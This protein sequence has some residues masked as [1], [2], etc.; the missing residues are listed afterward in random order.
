MERLLLPCLGGIVGA[1]VGVDV[2]EKV[3]DEG[4]G[5]GVEEGEGVGVEEGEVGAEE[6]EVLLVTEQSGPIHGLKQ[7]H[8]LSLLHTPPFTHAGEHNP[9]THD[10]PD[11][12]YTQ[13]DFFVF[14]FFVFVCLCCLY[15][16]LY[17]YLFL[18]IPISSS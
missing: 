6:G 1:G 10:F 16:F 13:L 2:V 15:F 9:V 5:V 14:L 8:I 11:V 18:Y 7:P 4:E 17:I 12:L 3:V